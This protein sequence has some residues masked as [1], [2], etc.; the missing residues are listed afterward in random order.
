MEP[1]VIAITGPAGSGKST[2]ASKLAECIDRCV[3]IDADSEAVREHHD[4]FSNATFYHD[5]VRID[6]TTHSEEDTVEEIL[7]IVGNGAWHRFVAG[8]ITS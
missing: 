2:T 6:S 8:E 7:G 3:N 4:Y 1:S 5:F